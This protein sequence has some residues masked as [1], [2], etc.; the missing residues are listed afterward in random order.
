MQCLG[1]IKFQNL[2]LSNPKQVLAGDPIEVT[3]SYDSNQV[4]QCEFVEKRS[5]VSKKVK[6]DM[7]KFSKSNS[8]EDIEVI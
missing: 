2:E 6:L 1:E 3:Y 8:I 7:N 5:G 4:M